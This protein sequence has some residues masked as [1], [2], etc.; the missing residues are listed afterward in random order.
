MKVKALAIVLSL[1]LAGSALA[2]AQ[3]VL[4]LWPHGTPE[5][6]QTTQP[7]K[8]VTTDQD[9][10]ING[11]RTTFDEYYR[12]LDD[13]LSSATF[14]GS[15]GSGG[16]FSGRRVPAAGV[17]RRRTRRLPLA[18]LDRYGVPAGEVSSARDGTL[19]G[20]SGRPAGR[21]AGHAGGACACRGVAHQSG[22]DWRDRLLGGRTSCGDAVEPLR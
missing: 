18:E 17:G 2:H 15:Y 10:L 6:P 12:A 7:E 11:H 9:A 4:P 22:A 3:Q 5:P 21:A 19:S 20:E 16:S 8:D 13:R 1:Q 14:H